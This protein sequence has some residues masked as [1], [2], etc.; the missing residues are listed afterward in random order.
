MYLDLLHSVALSCHYASHEQTRVGIS[1][2]SLFFL[3]DFLFRMQGLS[4]FILHNED[5]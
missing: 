3:F 2:Y 4:V 5:M 1:N